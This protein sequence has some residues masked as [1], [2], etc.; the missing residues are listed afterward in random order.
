MENIEKIQR[1]AE[2]LNEL[3]EK[4]VYVGGSVAQLYVSD[5]AVED[6]RPTIDVDCVVEMLSYKEYNDFC[7]LLRQ[8]KF[9][10]DQTPNAPICRWLFNDDIIDIMPDDADILGFSNK[11]YHPGLKNKEP[12]QLPNGRTIYIMPI[13]YYIATKLEAINSRGGGD[14][15]MSHDFEDIIFILNSC[16]HIKERVQNEKD[17]KLLSY[18]SK[19]MS[20]LL[21]RPNIKEEIECMLPIGDE[22]RVDFVIEIMDAMKI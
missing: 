20:T 4:V 15:R 11:W 5:N 1:I 3:N 13:T 16:Q 12:Y 22:E 2:G 18:L 7:E 8:R 21:S 9:R 17:E 14:L 10:N 6:A 19:E